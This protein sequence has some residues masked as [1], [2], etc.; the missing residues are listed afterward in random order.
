MN[1]GPLRIQLSWDDPATGERREP[2][3]TIPIALGRDFNEMPTQ[4]QGRP[5]SRMVLNS[6][7][8]SRC[9]VLIDSDSNGL[10]AID[11]NSRNGTFVDKQRIEGK[12]AIQPGAMFRVGRTWVRLDSLPPD[13]TQAA[14]A[15]SNDENLDPF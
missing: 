1:S 9:H 7:E 8:V 2:T 6:V 13:E 12:V 11:Q 4:V 15:I 10:V 3:L 5:V 14:E